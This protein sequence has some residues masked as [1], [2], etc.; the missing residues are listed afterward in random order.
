MLYDYQDD[1]DMF[2]YRLSA[3]GCIELHMYLTCACLQEVRPPPLDEHGFKMPLSVGPLGLKALSAR[4]LLSSLSPEA[5]T[6]MG[7]MAVKGGTS[8][9]ALAKYRSG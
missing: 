7:G 1:Q 9:A 6:E 5:W 3:F 8:E 4:D 2:F